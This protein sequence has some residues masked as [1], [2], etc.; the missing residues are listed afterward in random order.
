MTLESLANVGEFV[1]G[2]AVI[3][4]LLYLALQIRQNSRLVRAAAHQSLNEPTAR[5]LHAMAQ[6]P[7]AAETMT[8]GLAD[9]HALG[10]TESFQFISLVTTLLMGFQTQYFQN[11]DGLLPDDLWRRHRAAGQ[12]WLLSPGIRSVLKIIGPTFDPDFLREITPR[13]PTASGS[14]DDPPAA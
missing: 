11:R 7:P 14:T 4:T 5:V 8:K 3:I 9:F 13:T 10:P 1:G 2:V 6:G 12:G